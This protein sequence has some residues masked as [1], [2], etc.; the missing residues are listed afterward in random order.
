MAGTL[1]DR[2]LAVPWLRQAL[3][4]ARM[5]VVHRRYHL[6]GVHPSFYIH[7][8]SRISPDFRAGPYGLMGPGARICPGVTFGKYVMLAPEVLFLGGDHATDRPGVPII[9]SGRPPCP[10]TTVEDDV[11]IG[12][13]AMITAGVRIGR[14]AIVAAGAVVTKDVPPYAIVGGIPA[15]PI[16]QRF[17]T[18]EERAAH[19]RMLAEPARPG[20][21]VGPKTGEGEFGGW[22]D[23]PLEGER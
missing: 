13:R 20:R 5:A 15:K 1:R 10:P 2:L 16:G 14:G 23:D 19:D 12:Q 4:N 3:R 8:P 9:F 7:P 21:Y 18:D 17:A 22:R 6:A 11:W